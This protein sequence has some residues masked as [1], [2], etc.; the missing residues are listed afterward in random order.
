MKEDISTF[1]KEVLE[2]Q[3]STKLLWNINKLHGG[4]KGNKYKEV[5]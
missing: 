2:N 4:H 1:V 5:K 3:T